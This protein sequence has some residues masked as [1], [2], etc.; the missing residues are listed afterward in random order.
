MRREAEKKFASCRKFC[1]Y[2]S[3]G[4]VV[5]VTYYCEHHDFSVSSVKS[6]KSEE[7]VEKFC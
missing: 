5:D 4:P 7:H 3:F 2:E 1:K 6:S